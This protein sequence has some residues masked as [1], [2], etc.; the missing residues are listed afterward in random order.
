MPILAENVSQLIT[1]T[2]ITGRQ[3]TSTD[4]YLKPLVPSL[5]MF[6]PL[7]NCIMNFFKFGIRR[8]FSIVQ[9]T[10]HSITI[11]RDSFFFCYKKFDPMSPPWYNAVPCGYDTIT[12]I[13][14]HPF[15]FSRSPILIIIKANTFFGEN[16]YIHNTVSSV[17]SRH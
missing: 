6:V 16:F 2:V 17:E 11:V 7:N 1:I 9:S 13:S 4:Q 5:I 3:W 10:V 8:K 15:H 14:S 12:Y